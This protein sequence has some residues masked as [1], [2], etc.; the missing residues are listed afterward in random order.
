[1]VPC[2]ELAVRARASVAVTEL[3]VSKPTRVPFTESRL[4]YTLDAPSLADIRPW[5]RRVNISARRERRL[6]CVCAC[7]LFARCSRGVP[8]PD[9]CP[10]TQ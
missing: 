4:H 6:T 10:C 8:C 9:P 3:A 7:R 1:M 2:R 5:R